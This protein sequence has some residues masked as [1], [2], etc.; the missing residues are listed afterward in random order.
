MLLVLQERPEAAVGK[1]NIY[2]IP[3]DVVQ[4]TTVVTADVVDGFVG[5]ANPSGHTGH[6]GPASP[7]R[8]VGPRVLLVSRQNWDW[9][10]VKKG[11]AKG[12]GVL[13]LLNALS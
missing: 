10:V 1:S 13:N 3:A 5:A 2:E 6:L 11:Q 9:T 4:E 8:V 7:L 12:P